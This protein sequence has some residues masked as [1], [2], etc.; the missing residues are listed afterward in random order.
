MIIGSVWLFIAFGHWALYPL[1][2][3]WLGTRFYALYSLLHDAV[4]HLLLPDKRWN[5]RLARLFLA[6]PLF[7]SLGRMREAHFAHHRHLK[8]ELDPEHAHL[9][10]VEF[11]YPKRPAE[12]LFVF[13]GDLSGINFIRYRV[14]KW[15]RLAGSLGKTV[16]HMDRETGQRLVFMA[17]GAVGLTVLGGWEIFLLCGVLP[18]AT[19][20]QA[21][22]RLRLS[23]EHIH[24]SEARVFQ[25]RS[26]KAVWIE[27]V[28]LSPHNLGFHT[29]HHL[30]P[31]VPFYR[32]P[33]LHQKLMEEPLYRTHVQLDPGYFSVLKQY[34]IYT[35]R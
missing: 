31:G 35:R 20:Y 5:D 23:T 17:T 14:P 19:V 22:N 25:T 15:L 24:V 32:L 8:T 6:W 16:R 10:Y 27:R 4:H 3:F 28:L 29:E 12:L 26:V 2:W 13:L 9:R 30:Y 33:A 7:L 18:Y 21:L 34:I 1:L 11:R